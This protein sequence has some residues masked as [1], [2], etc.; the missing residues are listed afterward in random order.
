[1]GG[2]EGVAEA[3]EAQG[4]FLGFEE[5]EDG[6]AVGTFVGYGGLCLVLA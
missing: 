5:L 4:Y 6:G 1:M 2:D 3:A